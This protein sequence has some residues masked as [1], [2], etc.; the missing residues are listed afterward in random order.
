MA[1][2]DAA[3]IV[4]SVL[5]SARAT[6]SESQ[7]ENGVAVIDL[8]GATTGVAVFE[9][10]DLQYVSVI[11]VGGINVTNDIAIGLK[12]DPELADAVKLEHA[13]LDKE[14]ASELVEAKQDG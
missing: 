12:I 5:A 2:V 3:G 8:G 9:E 11:P 14:G 10:G 4:P 13:R 7:M 6:L 1:K